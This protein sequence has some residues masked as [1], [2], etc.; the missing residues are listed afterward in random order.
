MNAFRV[1]TRLNLTVMLV[2]IALTAASQETSA[3]DLRTDLEASVLMQQMASFYADSK[4][5]AV[6]ATLSLQ[7]LKDGQDSEKIT[8]EFAIAIRRPN[9]LSFISKGEEM[10]AM[11]VCDGKD[12]YAYD[13]RKNEYGVRPAPPHAAMIVGAAG[14][15]VTRIG[16]QLMAEV[17]RPQPFAILLKDVQGQQYLGEEERDGKKYH[18]LKFIHSEIDWE[19]WVDTGDNPLLA[20]LTMDISKVL[21]AAKAD[22]MDIAMSITYANWSLDGDMAGDIFQFKPPEGAKKR[23][24]Q[25]PAQSAASPADALKGKP[26]PPFSLDLLDGGTMDLASHKGKDVVIL[27]FWATWCGP[28][29]MDLP[30]YAKIANEYKDKGV[31]FYAVNLGD[32]PE[33]VQSFLK[34]TGVKCAV[35]MDRQKVTGRSYHVQNIPMSVIIDQSGKVEA[36][37]VGGSRDL[38]TQ[39]RTEID[40]LL[41]ET[42]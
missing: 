36:V 11:A 20:K 5:L 16:T 12:F 30:I 25:Q 24:L 18:H 28:C 32:T 26:A 31:V 15:G 21:K 41:K 14:A 42:P 8:K 29:R 1:F 27:D 7:N 40:A 22:S 13:A 35:A 37:H 9:E 4:T 33:A 3:D 2:L 23:E 34:S 19:M 17:F 10:E 38:E 6:D 39:L